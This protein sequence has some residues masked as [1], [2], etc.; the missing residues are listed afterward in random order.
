MTIPE[1][2]TITVKDRRYQTSKAELEEEF[3][4]PGMT[5]KELQDTFFRPFKVK[6]EN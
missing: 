3:D 6:T 5:E 2:R 4:M 1:P